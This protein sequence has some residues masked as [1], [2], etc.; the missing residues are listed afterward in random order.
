MRRFGWLVGHAV[1]L[2]AAGIDPRPLRDEAARV[3]PL[4]REASRK[5][6]M[7]WLEGLGE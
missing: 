7:E 4:L 3:G 5:M 2:A 6:F 1:E